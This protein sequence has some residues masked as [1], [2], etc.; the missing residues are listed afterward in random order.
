MFSHIVIDALFVLSV[1]VIWFMLGYQF[2]LC[3]AG[4]VYSHRAEHERRV[5]FAAGAEQG[6][7]QRPAS[8]PPF[9][10]TKTGP[11]HT[12]MQSPVRFD[13]APN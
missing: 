12:Y 11:L 2:V 7:G 1:V 6:L 13:A 5:A 10:N 4:W 3:V 8:R 9:T